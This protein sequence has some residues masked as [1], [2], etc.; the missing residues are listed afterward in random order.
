[1]KLKQCLACKTLF[2]LIQKKQ[3]SVN[4]VQIL[5]QGVPF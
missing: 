5:E 2:F 4:F 1:M 3:T